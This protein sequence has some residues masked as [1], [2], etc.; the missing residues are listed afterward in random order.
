MSDEI[1]MDFLLNTIKNLYDNF[2]KTNESIRK[3]NSEYYVEKS[4]SLIFLDKVMK[5]SY[6]HIVNS[7]YQQ[8]F[9]DYADYVITLND[10]VNRLHKIS[11]SEIAHKKLK[12]IEFEIKNPYFYNSSRKEFRKLK[13]QLSELDS[14]AF[15]NVGILESTIS[16]YQ[17]MISKIETL[18][19]NLEDEKK[20]GLYNYLPKIAYVLVPILISIEGMIL[21]EYITFNPYIPLVGY[22]LVLFLAYCILKSP[23]DFRILYKGSMN[24]KN[25]F[26]H[27]L[28]SGAIIIYGTIAFSAVFQNF[29]LKLLFIGM[30][31]ILTYVYL[32]FIKLVITNEKKYIIEHEFDKLHEEYLQ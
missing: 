11:L 20:S 31:L 27:L 5:K 9:D 7:L 29:T 22:I 32:S 30:F 2:K 23:N 8:N 3:Y 26:L 13:N 4:E 10:K 21:A 17:G 16:E 28:L 1:N 14:K 6:E 24:K 12:Q 19:D 18:E 15:S 25:I